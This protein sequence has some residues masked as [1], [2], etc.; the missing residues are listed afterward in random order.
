ML[1]LLATLAIFMLVLWPASE[2]EGIPAMVGCKSNFKQLGLAFDVYSRENNGQ[3]PTQSPLSTAATVNYSSTALTHYFKLSSNE[4]ADPRILI[5]PADIRTVAPT[6]A[7]LAA[8]NISYFLS[9]DARG[10][11]T[12]TILAGDRNLEVFGQSI[13]PGLYILTPGTVVTW[14]AG[15]HSKNTEERRGNLLLSDGSVQES[16]NNLTDIVRHQNIQTN[17]LVVP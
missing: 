15:L 6:F 1:V 17:R 16:R 7:S 2:R 5:C 12:N 14:T 9:V 4:V 3:Y 11:M 10:T 8:S 13:R